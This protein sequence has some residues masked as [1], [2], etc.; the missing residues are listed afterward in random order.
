MAKIKGLKTGT[1]VTK[2]KKFIKRAQ[3]GPAYCLIKFSQIKD[4]YYPIHFELNLDV[5]DFLKTVIGVCPKCGVLITS[6]ALSWA[7]II[8]SDSKPPLSLTTSLQK[9]AI[10][11]TCPN[12]GCY[13]DEIVICY[14]MQN[15]ER[16]Q[17]YYEDKAARILGLVE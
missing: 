5:D 6:N 2:I 14:R 13:S 15:D 4:I 8:Q 3:D 16:V 11:C 12:E 7:A 1:V 9:I 10:K 17:G